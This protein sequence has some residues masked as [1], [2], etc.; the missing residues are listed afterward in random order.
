MEQASLDPAQT[1]QSPASNAANQLI[2]NLLSSQS[3]LVTEDLATFLVAHHILISGNDS[4]ATI[5]EYFRNTP[6]I[7]E[8]VDDLMN[9]LEQANLIS[10]TGD[11]IKVSQRFVDIGGNVENLRRFLPRLFKLTTERVLDDASSGELKNKKEALR[12][13]ALPNDKETSSEAQAIYLEFKTKM[14]NLGAKV[15]RE[16]RK[17]EG[18]RLVGLFNCALVPED[19]V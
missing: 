8:I 2:G 5:K 1:R 11:K 14:L 6:D 7:L 17:A 16:G 10:M 9:A 12:Y 13:F 19:F 15:D 3:N 18:I 4:I